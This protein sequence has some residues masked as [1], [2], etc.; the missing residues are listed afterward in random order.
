MLQNVCAEKVLENVLQN[1]NVM[2]L[3]FC[4]YKDKE[5]IPML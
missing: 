2:T 5:D 4:K 3:L 1:N